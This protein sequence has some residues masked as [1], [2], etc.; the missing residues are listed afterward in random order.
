MKQILLGRKTGSQQIEASKIGRFFSQPFHVACKIRDIVR[1]LEAE[2][3]GAL[4][5]VPQELALEND[6]EGQGVQNAR[7]SLP[8]KDAR[9]G[10]RSPRT[11]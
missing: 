3:V 6:T 9:V 1:H 2:L 10:G 4:W 5:D 11:P 7:T 8:P